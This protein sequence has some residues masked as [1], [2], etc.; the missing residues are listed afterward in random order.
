M[1]PYLVTA[2]EIP[3][4]QDLWIRLTLNGETQQRA[5]TADII[6]GCAALIVLSPG[7]AASLRGT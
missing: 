2:D 3:D 6:Y 1:G 5:T 4:S 7:C